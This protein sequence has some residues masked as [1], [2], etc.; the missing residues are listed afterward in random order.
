MP[1]RGLAGRVSGK[2][3]L[4]R[5][6]WYA[7]GLRPSVP[8]VT[9]PA[10]SVLLG[11]QI[12]FALYSASKA[13]TARYRPM[14]DEMGLTYPQLLALMVL[15]ETDDLSVREL[16]DRLDLDSGTV[17]PMLKRLAA[18]G[19]VTRER[20]PEDERSV[21]IRLTDAGRALELP[22]CGMSQMMIDVLGM[23]S[24]Q[25]AELKQTLELI[26]ERTSFTA[27]TR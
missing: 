15:W 6:H 14:L 9:T 19:V 4:L 11:D 3:W 21:R 2:W 8:R 5:G 16:C 17:S 20:D 7:T 24:E 22:A 12:C 26:T 27:P 23:T 13:V 18:I 1:G 10:P 25:F